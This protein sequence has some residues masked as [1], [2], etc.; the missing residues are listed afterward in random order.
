M[1]FAHLAD[2][3]LGSWKSSKLQRL[4]MESFKFAIAR[5]IQEKVD[6]VLI[7]GDLFDAAIPSID[8]L[9]EAT[10]KLKELS[11]NNIECYIIPGSHD[12]SVSG[13][14]MIH[15]LE[16]AGL[17][18]NV[19]E[20]GSVETTDYF[21]TGLKGE[22]RGLEVKNVGSIKD[23]EKKNKF[24]ILMLHTT[25]KEMNL[26]FIDSVSLKDLPKGFDYYALG[27]IH[28]KK[29]FDKDRGKSK[30]V[31]PGALF[32]CNFSEL[33]H[34]H[35]GSFFIVKFD[36]V[37]GID[38]QE[39]KVKIKEVIN[40]D[41]NADNENP[42]SLKEKVIEK[43][44]VSV[45]NNVTNKIVTLRISGILASGKPSEID[46]R[47]I[48]EEFEKAGAYCVLRNTSKLMSKEFELAYKE[49]KDLEI[50]T[51]DIFN[52]EK[53]IIKKMI[54]QKIIEHGDKDKVIELMKCFDVEKIE[55]ETNDTFAYRLTNEVIKKLKLKFIKKC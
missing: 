42:Q 5:C 10:A 53:E 23:I 52:F 3:H 1:K 39:I 28:I 21:I 30:V 48:N 25:L 55:G 17:C 11:D 43:I 38:L 44:N 22:K 12:F 8:V 18:H 31:Y 14:S 33:E 36:K 46:F 35:F 15:V 54:E 4:N 47:I 20:S 6:F 13:K 50:D 37:K 45:T 19:A 41:I 7:A 24:K 29:I 26:P 9:K 32:P 2:C 16:K 34:F 51:V 27:H 49:L 40:F